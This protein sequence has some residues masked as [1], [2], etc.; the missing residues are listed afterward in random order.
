M[1]DTCSSFAD[2]TLAVRAGHTRSDFGE[3][4][5]AI[6]TSSSFVFDSA[7]QAAACFNGDE[8]GYIYSRFSNPTVDGFERRLAAMEGAEACIATSSGMSA[9]LTTVLAL[10]NQ[11]E[12]IVC[13]RSM[14]GAT[15]TLFEK[16]LPRF[17]ITCSWV[18]VADVTS[19]RAAITPDTRMMFLETPTNPLTEIADIKALSAIARE[20]DISLVVDNCFCTPALQKPLLLG[21]DYVVHSATKYLDGQ[22]RCIGGAIVGPEDSIKGDFLSIMR[23]G[24]PSMSPFN[25]WVFTKGLE[26]LGLRMQRHCDNALQ[27]AAWLVDQP[28]VKHVYF[29]GLESHPQHALALHQQSGFGGIVS[30]DMVDKQA[31]WQLIDNTRMLSITANLGDTRTTI[32]H[33]AS[34]THGRLSQEARERAG[35]GDGLVRIAVGLEHDDDIIADVQQATSR[36]ASRKRDKKLPVPEL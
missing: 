23:S 29:P 8:A 30:F 20:N 9:I 33:P 18:D 3:H 25:A 11:G 21:A 1:S 28:W 26:T 5:E 14:F 22:G 6:Y 31:A 13:A 2:E 4:S 15:V 19:W 24:G 17:G 32:T 36:T 12:H 10:L 7:Q 27:L 34:T 16:V 35:I